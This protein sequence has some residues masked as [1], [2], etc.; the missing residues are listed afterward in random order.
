MP[1]RVVRPA[2]RLGDCA[3]RSPGSRVVIPGVRPSQFPSGHDGRGLAAYSYGGSHG[4]GPDWSL[5]VFPLASPARTG[6]PAH[7]TK[8]PQPT[9]SVKVEFPDWCFAGF[10]PQP[11][12]C[13]W[14]GDE[15]SFRHRIPPTVAHRPIRRPPAH[16]ELVAEPPRQGRCGY[17]GG[18]PGVRR[19]PS[20][21]QLTGP[22]RRCWSGSTAS[23]PWRISK[24]NCGEVTEPVAPTVAI[25]WPRRTV[26]PRRTSTRSAWA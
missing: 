12:P 19:R 22:P 24:C 14:R 2:H 6:E 25:S 4:I 23:V 10:A 11:A 7:G 16:A 13:Q 21:P 5:T 18:A 9:S 15:A 8:I 20:R 3:G 1:L 26:S 17:G